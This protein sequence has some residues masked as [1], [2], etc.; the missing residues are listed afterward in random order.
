MFSKETKEIKQIMLKNDN[1]DTLVERVFNQE[2][3]SL[4]TNIVYG[5][6]K[7]PIALVS[8]YIG[9]QSTSFE[10]AIRRITEKVYHSVKPPVIFKSHPILTP[11]GKDLIINKNSSSVVYT[12]QCCCEINYIDQT[13]RHLITRIK[14][15]VP[16]CV[17]NFIQNPVELKST[18]IKKA[19]N[20][21]VI[22]AHLVNNPTCG[23]SYNE[24]RF[25]ILRKCFNKYDLIKLET[26]LIKI[27]KPKFNKQKD[28]DYVVSLL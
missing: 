15:H 28:L 7:C 19:M 10:R 13:S 6:E 21:S 3:K 14:Q 18:A 12:F 26:I 24:S 11:T 25:S 2:S 17:E 16:K 4:K 23:K 1:P 22:S 27:N 9:S 20:R 5:P 8:P